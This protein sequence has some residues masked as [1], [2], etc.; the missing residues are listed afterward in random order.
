[1]PN[2]RTSSRGLLEKLGDDGVGVQEWAKF[3]SDTKL[4]CTL[5]SKAVPIDH[6]GMWQVNQHISGDSHKKISQARFSTTQPKFEKVQES[7]SIQFFKKTPEIR[8]LEAECLWALKIAEEDWSFNSSD[9]T[10]LLFRRMFGEQAVHSFSAGHT[11]MSYIVR[12][13]L[14]EAI[15]NE[16]KADINSSEGTFTFMLDET[17]TA[18]VKKQCDFLCRYWSEASDEVITR[19]VTSS[20]FAHTSAEALKN[21]VLDVF[22]SADIDIEKL[23]NL[24]LDGPNINKGLHRRVDA[25]LREG[26][27]RSGLLDFHPC[28]LH[29]VHTGFHRGICT[30]GHDVENLAFELHSWFKI[31]PCKREDF[32]LVSVEFCSEIV[33]AVFNRDEALFYRHVETRWLT[34]VPALEKVEER[35]DDAKKYFIEYL[36]STKDFQKCTKSNKRY[37][38]IVESLKKEKFLLIQIAFVVDVSSCFTSFLTV[39][40]SEGPKI[41]V[42]YQAMKLLVKTL[43]LR[44]LKPEFVNGINGKEL[45]KLDI[46]KKETHL[47]LENIEIGSK[48]KRLMKNTLTAFEVKSERQKILQFYLS[49]VKFLQ[50]K[51]SFDNMVIAAAA[52]LHPDQRK[53]QITVRNIEYLAKRFDHVI[54]EKEVSQIKDEWKLYQ[55]DSNLDETKCRIDH[56]WGKVLKLKTLAGIY[57][58]PTLRRLVKSVLTLHHGNA[59]VERS[60]SDNK[61]TCTKDRIHLNDDTLIGLRRMKEYARSAGGAHNAVVTPEMIAGMKVAKQKNDERIHQEKKDKD[62]AAKKLEEAASLEKQ[63]EEMIK[64]AD[65]SKKSLEEKE[66]EYTEVEGKVND[67]FLLSKRMLDDANKSLKSAIEKNDMIGI[68]VASELLSAAQDKMKEVEDMGE[69]RKKDQES[70]CKKRKLT[71]DTM[72]T[73]I[74]QSCES[75]SLSK[76]RKVDD[77]LQEAN[78]MTSVK[79]S[80]TKERKD[81][82]ESVIPSSKTKKKNSSAEKDVKKKV[83]QKDE[84][85]GE[86]LK[87]TKVKSKV[88]SGKRNIFSSLLSGRKRSENPNK[89][90]KLIKKKSKKTEKCD[91][92]KLFRQ[93]MLKKTIDLTTVDHLPIKEE[94][95]HNSYPIT[96]EGK[97]Y[98]DLKS[99][100]LSWPSTVEEM[101]KL[102][103]EELST[104]L[105]TDAPRLEGKGTHGPSMQWMTQEY[106]DKGFLALESTGDGNCLFNCISIFLCGDES[107]SALLRMMTSLELQMHAAYYVTHPALENARMNIPHVTDV[108]DLMIGGEGAKELEKSGDLLAA[109]KVEAKENARYYRYAAMIAL[110]GLA[111]IT[112]RPIFSVYPDKEHRFFPLLHQEICPRGDKNYDPLHIQWT[113]M[114]EKKK[115]YMFNPNHFVPLIQL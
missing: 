111:T 76:V 109:V 50:K 3:H 29:K 115:G 10:K 49:T 22:Q 107:K 103:S 27:N 21:M 55:A 77:M 65:K 12:H 31:S 1:M 32:M 45:A 58:Y 41:H 39:F 43:M 97:I 25:Y 95:I 33:F 17:T 101:F 75:R 37:I 68:K 93:S 28:P 91:K 16:L 81:P 73:K 70:L 48:T 62:M 85:K 19:Y 104:L 105:Q 59:D 4:W 35:W 23:S 79:E 52:C 60:L 2:G 87:K 57:K 83:T 34:L 36:P 15:L 14:S 94:K 92:G 44:F 26:T 112:Q 89:E 71:I 18:Q 5:C 64:N 110:M 96:P 99:L 88:D 20:F 61:N 106:K 102:Y 6:G 38:K 90:P 113:T 69:K 82:I 98:N 108:E 74:K 53:N 40:Q 30:Y 78:E 47:E 24:S 86:L 51:L 63:K 13:G 42:L 46:G 8:S 66:R 84:K 114:G 7:S 54:A 100:Y 9:N 56:Y 72:Y 67:E 80:L 11:K